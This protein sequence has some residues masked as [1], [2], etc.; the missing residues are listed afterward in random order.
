[1]LHIAPITVMGQVTRRRLNMPP[2]REFRPW[3]A[4]ATQSCLAL[5]LELPTLQTKPTPG[6]DGADLRPENYNLPAQHRFQREA[7]CGTASRSAE[8]SIAL[9]PILRGSDGVL[10]S[11]LAV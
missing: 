10:N 5:P 3:P 2:A 4:A 9:P 1:M 11:R 8:R 7:E 6:C